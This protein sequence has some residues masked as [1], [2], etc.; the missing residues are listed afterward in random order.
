MGRY[1]SS[2]QMNAAVS[3]LWMFVRCPNP[4]S[5]QFRTVFRC[6]TIQS[7]FG[8]KPILDGTVN[9]RAILT[10]G[11]CETPVLVVFV[12]R[13]CLAVAPQKFYRG[14]TIFGVAPLNSCA[15]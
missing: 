12:E 13:L 3:S 1:W 10:F 15:P 11:H 9:A 4:A 14:S 7:N 5:P 6:G 2:L 8:P